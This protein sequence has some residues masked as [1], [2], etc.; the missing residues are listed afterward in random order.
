M[1]SYIFV[2]GFDKNSLEFYCLKCNES[3]KH[4]KKNKN[5]DPSHYVIVV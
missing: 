1:L 2:Y 4:E 5:K 3:K